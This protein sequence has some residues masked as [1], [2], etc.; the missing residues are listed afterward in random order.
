MFSLISCSHWC[1]TI[2]VQAQGH[3]HE[4]YFSA[5]SAMHQQA[6]YMFSDLTKTLFPTPA[7]VIGKAITISAMIYLAFLHYSPVRLYSGGGLIWS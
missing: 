1:A 3:R 6:A 2:F 4:C 5:V 7:A